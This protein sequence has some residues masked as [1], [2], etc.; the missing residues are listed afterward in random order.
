[1]FSIG[2]MVL[3]QLPWQQWRMTSILWWT[4]NEALIGKQCHIIISHIWGHCLGIRFRYLKVLPCLTVSPVKAAQTRGCVESILMLKEVRGVLFNR[5]TNRCCFFVNLSV[6]VNRIPVHLPL[7]LETLT[8]LMWMV[9]SRD[10]WH[11]VL[12]IMWR[13]VRNECYTCFT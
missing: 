13:G 3:K 2:H 7:H 10:H 4:R 11:P 1:M 6:T 9:H 5:S 8:F 12:D